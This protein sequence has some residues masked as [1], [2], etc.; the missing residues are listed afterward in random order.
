MNTSREPEPDG[1]FSLSSS[2]SWRSRFGLNC[3]NFLQAESAGVI[4]P[5]VLVFLADTHWSYTTIG[6]VTTIGGLGGLVLQT[7]AG[8]LADRV[9][10]FRLLF[11]VASV[12]TGA[13]LALLPFVPRAPAWIGGLLFLNGIAGTLFLPVLAALA[14]SLVGDVRLP[15]LM[16]ENQGWNHA[17]NIFA[18]LLAMY[19]LHRLGARAAFAS[20]AVASWLGAATMLLIR[21]RELHGETPTV[22]TLRAS[23]KSGSGVGSWRLLLQDRRIWILFIAASSA[24]AA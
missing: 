15:R 23:V 22:A 14:L 9:R 8:I 10:R 18:A 17:G 21:R 7:P 1:S 24:N 19:F 16:G 2:L 11:V 13:C 5:V 4:G 6:V 20:A 3:A 12:L